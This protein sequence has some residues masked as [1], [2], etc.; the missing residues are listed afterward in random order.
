MLFIGEVK[1]ANIHLKFSNGVVQGTNTN[2]TILVD[3]SDGAKIVG[4]GGSISFSYIDNLPLFY[5]DGHDHRAVFA[6]TIPLFGNDY[7]TVSSG[8]TLIYGDIESLNYT[9]TGPSDVTINPTGTQLYFYTQLLFVP[10][11][12]PVNNPAISFGNDTI[13]TGNGNDV[14]SGDVAEQGVFLTGGS[15]ATSNVLVGA[16]IGDSDKGTTFNGLS[17]HYGNDS[18][19]TGSGNNSAYGDVININHTLIDGH[20][21][22]NGYAGVS[23]LGVFTFGNDTITGGN[24]TNLIVGD[25]GNYNVNAIAGYNDNSGVANWQV[26]NYFGADTLKGGIGI[27]QIYGDIQNLNMTGTGGTQCSGVTDAEFGN[28]HM[29]FGNDQIYGGGGADVLVGDVGTWAFNATGG[30]NSTQTPYGV[31]VLLA[32]MLNGSEVVFGNDTIIE[33]SGSGS[34]YG[35]IQNINMNFHGGLNINGTGGIITLSSA[36]IDM[37]RLDGF[38]NGGYDDDLPIKFGNDHLNGGTGNDIL[39]GDGGSWNLLAVAGTAV[40]TGS[41]VGTTVNAGIAPAIICGANYLDGGSG[42]DT[43]I[44]DWQLLNF[45]LQDGLANGH[46]GM[47]TVAG[48]WGFDVLVDAYAKISSFTFGNSTLIG[49]LGNDVLIGDAQTFKYFHTDY[50]GGTVLDSFLQN[51][52]TWGNDILFGG[53]GNDQLTGDVG[54]F[55]NNQGVS[56]ATG[57]DRFVYDGQISN[58]KDTITDFNKNT[59]ALVGQNGA[60]FHDGGHNANGDLVIK[61]WDA[62]GQNSSNITLLGVHDN[63]SA[64][65]GDLTY[66]TTVIV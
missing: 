13:T 36:G 41:G 6:P 39:C 32:E 65:A 3:T 20:D 55:L 29:I 59:D 58:G 40:D 30:S 66:V 35:D 28:S 7:I 42:T 44:G 10:T 51:N 8:N 61:V 27:D 12:N 47:D 53:Q 25:V 56:V 57:H 5:D 46:L 9:L 24:Q 63:F 31:M 64:L 52:V 45:T 26:I 14:I 37:D 4:D 1:M 49:G 11:T 16:F 43:L 18:I 38:G 60:T 15:N 23:I 21:V 48:M 17:I 34:L 50:N 2:D 33:S 62:S 22:P 54:T 19:T